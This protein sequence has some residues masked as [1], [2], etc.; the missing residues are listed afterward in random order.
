MTSITREPVESHDLQSADVI[1]RLKLKDYVLID[2]IASR[3]Y[4]KILRVIDSDIPTLDDWSKV[5]DKLKWILRT[6]VEL[7]GRLYVC[8][9]MIDRLIV[10]EKEKIDSR[11]QELTYEFNYLSLDLSAL[12]YELAYSTWN[13]L[14]FLDPDKHFRLRE[15]LPFLPDTVADALYCPPAKPSAS[16]HRFCEKLIAK[17]VDRS[18]IK[19]AE[20][21]LAQFLHWVQKYKQLIVS[22]YEAEVSAEALYKFHYIVSTATYLLGISLTMKLTL[23]PVNNCIQSILSRQ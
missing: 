15:I 18:G 3:F 10:A 5:D 17:G 8:E 23:K 9:E 20:I 22:F 21:S 12:F 11:L 16:L 1:K 19:A 2:E 4:V 14:D 7:L 13:L 6:Q